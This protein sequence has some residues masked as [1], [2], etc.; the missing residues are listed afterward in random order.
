MGPTEGYRKKQDHETR[1]PRYKVEGY[2]RNQTVTQYEGREITLR[3][4][5]ITRP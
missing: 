1:V 4:V 2:V 3:W 5:G